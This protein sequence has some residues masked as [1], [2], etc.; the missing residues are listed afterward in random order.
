MKHLSIDEII[1]FVS[2]T[3]LNGDSITISATVNGHIRKCEKCLKL[4]RSF[5]MVYDAF[6]RLQVDGDFKKY[7]TEAVLKE[8]DRN[9]ET[10]ALREN[11][12][13]DR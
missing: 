13:S 1:D 4:V 12:D 10:G 6:S 7:V 5:Q 11:I 3:E 2:L 9:E 8:Q